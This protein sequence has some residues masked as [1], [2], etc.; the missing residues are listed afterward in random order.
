MFSFRIRNL[1]L[2]AEMARPTDRQI[3][4]LKNLGIDPPP[5]KAVCRALLSYIMRGV[6]RIGDQSGERIAIIKAAQQKYT[7]QEIVH[8]GHGAKGKVLY[9]QCR[10]VG[11]RVDMRSSAKHRFSHPLDVW[12]EW[13]NGTRSTTSVGSIRLANEPAETPVP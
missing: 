13:E 6:A 11:G 10:G 1:E 5:T 3:E 8:V 2:E 4:A 9:I 7:N 12:V